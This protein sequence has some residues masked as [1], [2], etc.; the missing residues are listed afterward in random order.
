MKLY[1]LTN[2]YHNALIALTDSDFDEQTISDTLEGL[3]GELEI[4]AKNVAAFVENRKA[5]ISAVKE[6]SKKLADRARSEQKHLDSLVEYLKFNMDQSGITEIRSPELI[7]KIKKNPPKLVIDD[8]SLIDDRFY[9]EV[10][11]TRKLF[12]AAI[13]DE[14]KAGHAVD[15]AHIEQNTRLEI[16]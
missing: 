3:K 10:P 5:E 12:N 16:K 7:L 8:E 15:G 11:A 9:I 14:I 2:E 4:K 6:A 13:K 1:E